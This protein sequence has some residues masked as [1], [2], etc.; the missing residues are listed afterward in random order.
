MDKC[1]N[2]KL[3]N[4]SKIKPYQ[5]FNNGIKERHISQHIPAATAKQDQLYLIV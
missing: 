2:N 1:V 3:W 4:Q 5:I